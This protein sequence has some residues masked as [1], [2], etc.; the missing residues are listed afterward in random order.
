M[1]FGLQAVQLFLGQRLRRG[2]GLSAQHAQDVEVA[3]ILQLHET[4]ADFLS[5]GPLARDSG[6]AGEA[7]PAAGGKGDGRPDDQAEG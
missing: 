6:L 3:G 2:S 4:L 1:R 7:L 5:P